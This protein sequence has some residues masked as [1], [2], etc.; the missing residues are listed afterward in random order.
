MYIVFLFSSQH[1]ALDNEIC[2]VAY[3]SFNPALSNSI[4]SA[5]IWRLKY[6]RISVTKAR[7]TFLHA[8]HLRRLAVSLED[9]QNWPLI[10]LRTLQR[11]K[12]HLSLKLPSERV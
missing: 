9:P 12:H 5:D 2:A 10:G 6:S 7:K 4:I 3:K 8:R 11:K 1:L